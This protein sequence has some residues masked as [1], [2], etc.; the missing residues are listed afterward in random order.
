MIAGSIVMGLGIGGLHYTGMYAMRLPAH[1]TM[2]I[3][4]VLLSVVIAVAVSFVALQL[5]FRLRSGTRSLTPVKLLAAT[6][7][8]AAG[9]GL[10]YTGIAAGES[11]Q[12]SSS[13]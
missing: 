1:V 10:Q 9:I 2:D 3:G 4:V 11:L 8:G 5:A 13:E 7:M 12:P 6:V